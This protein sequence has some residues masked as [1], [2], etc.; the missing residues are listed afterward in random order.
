MADLEELKLTINIKSQ[1]S[2]NNQQKERDQ[3]LK[4]KRF[5]LTGRNGDFYEQKPRSY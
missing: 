3:Q 4:N 2:E 1:E 5:A